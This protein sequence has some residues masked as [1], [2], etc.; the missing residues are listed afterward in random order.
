[1]FHG[2]LRD[3]NCN[4]IQK[5]LRGICLHAQFYDRARDICKILSN[6][7]PCRNDATALICSLLY[8]RDSTSAVLDVL[9][10]RHALED[11]PRSSS[12]S[13][14]NYE[15]RFAAQMA[16]YN[17]HGQSVKL[18]ESIHA[19]LLVSNDGVDESQRVSVLSAAT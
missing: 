10:Y 2:S 5:N 3:T 13:F 18:P 12:E 7:Q 1:M 17:S 9:D 19:L 16:K 4:N 15:L 8:M 6:E 14:K 11:N